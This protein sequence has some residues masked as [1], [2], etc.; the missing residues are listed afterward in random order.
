LKKALTTVR[1]RKPFRSRPRR[2]AWLMTIGGLVAFHWHAAPAQPTA[3][4]SDVK[5]TLLFNL[6]NFVEWPAISL[7]NT[8]VPFVLAI[9]GVD[10][11]GNFLDELVKNERVYQK[12]IAVRRFRRVEEALDAQV[13]FISKSEQSRLQTILSVLKD[14]PILTVSDI[15][16]GAFSRLGGM[17]ELITQKRTVQIHVNLDQARAAG[18]TLNAKL[19]QV[20]EIVHSERN[21][22]R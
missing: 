5:A 6:C 10:P 21:Y 19:L 9:L 2:L 15:S 14:R 20:A 8:N 22:E 13:L 1:S 16:G 4:E 18:L 17:I 3:R 12:T 11:F 7:S